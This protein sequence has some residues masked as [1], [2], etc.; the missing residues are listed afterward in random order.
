MPARPGFPT[1]T[2]KPN[3]REGR[4][5][6]C[7]RARPA[8]RSSR[9]GGA[10]RPVHRR[11]RFRARA[12][13][14]VPPAAYALAARPHR[15]L[16]RRRRVPEDRRSAGDR[17]ASS[18]S[19]SPTTSR[20][21]AWRQPMPSGSWARRH[22]RTTCS[23]WWARSRGS[24][25]APTTRAPTS[26][27][28]T[29]AARSRDPGPAREVLQ[30]RHARA[31]PGGRAPA[32]RGARADRRGR[33]AV[34]RHRGRAPRDPPRRRPHHA[35]TSGWRSARSR[36]RRYFDQPLQRFR[37]QPDRVHALAATAVRSLRS[38]TVSWS[39][40]PTARAASPGLGYLEHVSDDGG[41]R[42]ISPWQ[43][44][45]KPLDWGPFVWRTASERSG[46]TSGTS[47][48]PNERRDAC[49]PW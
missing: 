23:R 32:R 48:E 42:L 27:S 6:R 29:P 9:A 7:E 46:S 38:S 37:V 11:P 45:P 21:N 18:T 4:R 22:R 43:T 15:R 5:A 10:H 44:R 20:T 12:R 28:W 33:R 26:S 16:P 31:R 35:S 17:R 13:W 1:H 39:G 47:S 34:L 3:L 40:S 14:R 30:G 2:R 49:R 36:W 41:L 8:R 19:A 25:S 24:A